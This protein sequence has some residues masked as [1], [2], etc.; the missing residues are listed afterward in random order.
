MYGLPLHVWGVKTLREIVARC[1]VFLAVDNETLKRNRLDIAR[2]QIETKLLGYINFVIKIRVQ[3]AIYKVRVVEEGVGPAELEL[4]TVEDPLGWSVV[5]S[6]CHSGGGGAAKAVLD[7]LD[8][9]DSE[10][11]ASEE[12]QQ[13]PAQILSVA[14]ES[15]K[16]VCILENCTDR[17]FDNTTL[18][19]PI[20]S[21]MEKEIVTGE[22]CVL[23][24]LVGVQS[25]RVLVREGRGGQSEVAP[26][27]ECDVNNLPSS[28][29]C[30]VFVDPSSIGPANGFDPISYVGRDEPIIVA[31]PTPY[32]GPL[33]LG[34][35]GQMC[36]IPLIEK[37]DKLISTSRGKVDGVH[38]S[39]DLS[40]SFDKPNSLD[41]LQDPNFTNSKSI[42]HRKTIMRLPFPSMAGHKCLRLVEAISGASRPIRRRKTVAEDDPTRLDVSSISE[43]GDKCG[44]HSLEGGSMHSSSTSEGAT[45]SIPGIDLT[46]VLH[47]RNPPVSHSGVQL[48]LGEHSLQDVDGFLTSRDD[49]VCKT[50]EAEALITVQQDLGI[51]FNSADEIPTD[52]LINLEDRD[53][54]ELAK[55]QESNGPQ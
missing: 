16:G 55:W 17:T 35:G 28:K 18:K 40:E 27:K 31:S 52:R 51:L 1:G 47:S 7:G 23:G 21:N 49:P 8:G 26:A 19:M 34:K 24:E 38:E 3:G 39:S 22:K 4:L 29:D 12:C 46:V 43:T 45:Q 50:L 10:S 25:P 14:V 2:V 42:R 20:P 5:A 33:S 54:N 53:R 41:D 32:T 36:N 15:T 11:G 48:L 6:S 9:E 30:A 13:D 37:F 44:Q